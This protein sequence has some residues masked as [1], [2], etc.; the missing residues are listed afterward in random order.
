MRTILSLFHSYVRRFGPDA[1]VVFDG[2]SCGPRV[3]DQEHQRRSA[4]VR[5]V[6]PCRKLTE[7]TTQIGPQEPFL[8]NRSNKAAFIKLLKEYLEQTGIRVAQA[9]GDGDTEIVSGKW[10]DRDEGLD[11]E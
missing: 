7:D 3:K 11:R 4:V 5:L 9:E 8:A 10:M 6:A 1:V 2:Y